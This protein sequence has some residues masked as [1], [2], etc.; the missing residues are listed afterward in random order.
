MKKRI[1]NFLLIIILLTSLL[2]V[3]GCGNN[4]TD[5]SNNESNVSNNESKETSE[6][7]KFIY[8]INKISDEWWNAVNTDRS[9][10]DIKLTNKEVYESVAKYTIGNTTG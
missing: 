7:F 1:T 2:T 3:T 8:D 4:K 10:G 5:S 6:G 9:V